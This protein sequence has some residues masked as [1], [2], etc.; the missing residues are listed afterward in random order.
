MPV[1]GGTET[2]HIWPQAAPPRGPL[3]VTTLRSDPPHVHLGQ[4]STLQRVVS[5]SPRRKE[6]ALSQRL[7]PRGKQCNVLHTCGFWCKNVSLSVATVS[8]SG[9]KTA[10]DLRAF[11]KLYLPQAFFKETIVFFYLISVCFSWICRLFFF[12]F[13]FSNSTIVILLQA[14][15]VLFIVLYARFSRSS[16]HSVSALNIGPIGPIGP[17]QYSHNLFNYK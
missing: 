9:K 6:T 14:F 7:S 8:D 17:D 5:P 10:E 15:S 16:R 13:F 11:V 12:C 1:R 3:K 2:C 4:I